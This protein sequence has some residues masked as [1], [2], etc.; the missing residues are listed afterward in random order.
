MNCILTWNCRIMKI[1]QPFKVNFSFW[2]SRVNMV[3]IVSWIA[4]DFFVIV[5]YS[6]VC[7]II[8][9]Y[10]WLI[11]YLSCIHAY[12][13]E[14]HIAILLVFLIKQISISKFWM[15]IALRW[16]RSIPLLM[17]S[18]V[19]KIN[20]CNYLATIVIMFLKS[21]NWTT[22]EVVGKQRQIHTHQT[23]RMHTPPIFCI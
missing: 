21:N 22:G 13:E 9:S 3:S 17:R 16:S 11:A 15:E 4:W 14:S 20:Y 8:V 10:L 6:F 23:K 1:E 12:N 2:V 19:V 18:M 5:V 7:E